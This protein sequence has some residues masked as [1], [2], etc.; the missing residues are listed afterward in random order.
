MEK[1]WEY[2]VHIAILLAGE[3][4]N[5]AGGWTY[6]VYVQW[7]GQG[8][9]GRQQNLIL[10]YKRLTLS[11]PFEQS[12]GQNILQPLQLCAWTCIQTMKIRPVY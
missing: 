6:F 8:R 1:A 7:Q 3:E 9:G 12:T 4:F 11:L 10:S 5:G 2:I